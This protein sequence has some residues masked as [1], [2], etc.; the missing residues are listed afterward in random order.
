MF[1]FLF[2][3]LRLLSR[4]CW[5]SRRTFQHCTGPSEGE[6]RRKH[7][8]FFLIKYPNL[9]MKNDGLM[10]VFFQTNPFWT[11]VSAIVVSDAIRSLHVWKHRDGCFFRMTFNL[12]RG[13]FWH[14]KDELIELGF[15]CAAVSVCKVRFATDVTADF[16][17]PLV[18]L[19]DSSESQRS[20]LTLC[21]QKCL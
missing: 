2:F 12:G 18:W 14:P 20:T 9:L 8:L 4:R 1:S 13:W 15:F 3:L 7:L 19:N 10:R 16:F 17:F 5:A 21:L 11:L 6:D